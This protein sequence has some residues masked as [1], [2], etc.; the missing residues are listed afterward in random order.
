MK[1]TEPGCL[2]G[3]IWYLLYSGNAGLSFRLALL[4]GWVKNVI[5]ETEPGSLLE[6]IWSLLYSGNAII[7]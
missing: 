2:L 1:E 7:H 4:R 3:E 5:K 6:E